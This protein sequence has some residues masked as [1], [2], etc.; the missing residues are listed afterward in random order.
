MSDAT[1]SDASEEAPEPEF[2][3]G[4][5]DKTDPDAP[6]IVELRK[7]LVV[8]GE[9]V[10]KLILRAPLGGDIRRCGLPFMVGMGGSSG[11]E[12]LP[13]V[14]EKGE[15]NMN[16]VCKYIARLGSV[17]MVQVDKM[18]HDDVM[19]CYVAILPFFAG[20]E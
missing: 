8:G 6:V 18:P 19:K 7:P 15:V 4:A 13:D 20:L 2:V 17:P 16:A 1:I 10:K 11:Y 14:E 3:D 12:A 5:K 9:E